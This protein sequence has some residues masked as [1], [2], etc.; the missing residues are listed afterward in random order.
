MMVTMVILSILSAVAVPYAELSVRRQSEYELKSALREIRQAIDEFH[1]DW[2][3]GYISMQTSAASDDG[4]PTTLTVL[5]EGVV[6]D[7]GAIEKR[8]Y[9]LRR[10]PKN[11]FVDPKLL[12]SDHWQLRSYQDRPD[13]LFWGRQD[14]YDVK[15]KTEKM[16]IDGTPY[17]IW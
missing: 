1:R 5:V 7:K 14:V 9:Y 11:P 4:Y 3:A 13:A 17:S 16:A 15:P 6:V 10:I 12:P 8:R 2:K